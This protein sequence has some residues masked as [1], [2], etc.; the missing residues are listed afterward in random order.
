MINPHWSYAISF[1]GAALVYQFGWSK[2]YPPLSNAILLFISSTIV[3]HLFLGWL[4]K[5]K[6]KPYPLASEQV[7]PIAVT[8]FLFCFWIIEFVYARGIPLVKIILQQPY[9]YRLFGIP[10]LHVF[11]VTFASFYTVFLFHLYLTNRKRIDLILFFINLS[12]SLLIYSRAMF[13]FI[14]IAS[15]FIFL[16]STPVRLLPLAMVGA[17]SVFGFLYFFGVLGNMRES[18]EAKRSYDPDLFMEVGQP[19]DRFNNSII[20]K[21]FFWSYIYISSPL[22]NLQT[23]IQS[24]QPLLSKNVIWQHINN[25]MLFDFISKRVNK[26]CGWERVKEK[27]IPGPFNVSTVYSRSFSYQGWWGLALMAV[28]VSVFPWVYFWLLPRN[29]Y[30]LTGAAILSTM[31]L[32]LVYDNTIRFT[33]LGLQLVYPFVFPLFLQVR[34]WTMKRMPQ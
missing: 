17:I 8:F 28:F 9:N 24:P 5:R 12:S 27:T 20:P 13:L 2:I 34:S 7:S 1:L 6:W 21:E 4:W 15:L 11:N 33:G 25:E 19:T 22:A 18:A 14:L 26:I 29:P 16:T 30:S 10:S 31:Y 3:I 23:N 32:F